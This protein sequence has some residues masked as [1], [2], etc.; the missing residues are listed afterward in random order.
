MLNYEGDEEIRTFP[1]LFDASKILL[2]FDEDFF[3]SFEHS[4]PSELITDN[5]ITNIK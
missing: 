1:S 2:S 4:K 5:S 3:D